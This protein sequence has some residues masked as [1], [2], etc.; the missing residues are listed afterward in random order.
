MKEEYFNHF[1]TYEHK[2][3]IFFFCWTFSTKLILWSNKLST[4]FV[5]QLN[6]LPFSPQ[7]YSKYYQSSYSTLSFHA[8]VPR[9]KQ[10]NNKTTKESCVAQRRRRD[11]SKMNDI[12][13]PFL[14]I[15]P[16]SGGAI[17]CRRRFE[18]Q[19]W[20]KCW[21]D[22]ERTAGGFSSFFFSWT[23][24]RRLLAG[25]SASLDEPGFNS[26]SSNRCGS[27]RRGGRRKLGRGAPKGSEVDRKV[28][29]LPISWARDKLQFASYR[30][31]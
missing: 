5:L 25:E 7:K 17:F 18:R 16:P 14:A 29:G 6:S 12:I 28:S 9:I 11:A 4:F 23:N 10:R 24:E 8:V 27:I 21:T 26:P 13:P 19:R 1:T 31:A 20:T 3:Q 15:S 22:V 2:L 30:F